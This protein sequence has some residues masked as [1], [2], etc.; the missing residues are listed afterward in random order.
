[1]S[2]FFPEVFLKI[3]QGYLSGQRGFHKSILKRLHLKDGFDLEAVMN[4]ELTF[5]HPPPRIAFVDLG[6]IKIRPKGYQ[7]SMEKIASAIMDEAKKHKRI[8][9][10]ESCSFIRCSELLYN[11]IRST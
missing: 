1:M 11:T 2:L 7:P 3:K 8:K 10:L 6:D 5:M 9:R 4:I